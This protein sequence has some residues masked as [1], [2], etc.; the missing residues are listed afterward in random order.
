MKFGFRTGGFGDE[1]LCSVLEKLRNIGYDGVEL[2]LESRE[3]R[4]EN[5]TSSTIAEVRGML[6]STGL[7]LASVSYHADDENMELR[8]PNTFRAIDIAADLGS[9]VLILNAERVQGG[10]ADA[11]FEVVVERF[12]QLC[13]KAEERDITLAVEPEPGMVVHGTAD[14]LRLMERVGSSRLGVNLDVGHAQCTEDYLP[15]TI[16]QLGGSI[17][18]AHI[19]DIAGRV[20]KHLLPGDGDID[21]TSMFAAFAEIGYEGYYTI[22]LFQIA[23]DPAGYALTALERIR[24]YSQGGLA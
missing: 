11:M 20:H 9:K 10:S 5:Q 17:V 1:P 23:D 12:G 3:L 16:R 22:D 15:E 13:S 24:P 14:M 18:H 21:F 4:P 2:C 7:D 6:S 19:E 8:L